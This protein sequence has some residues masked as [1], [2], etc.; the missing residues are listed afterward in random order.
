VLMGAGIPREI[1]GILDR[2]ANHERTSMRIQ[3]EGA[4]SEEETRMVLDPPALL[5]TLLPPLKRP[6]F[7]AI[8]SSDVL[9]QMLVQKA[10]GRIDGFVVE[11]ATAGGHNAP[12][13]GPLRL[14]ETGEPVYGPRD[15]ANLEKIKQ[16]GLP[17]WLAG[18]Y[19]TQ[20]GM[21]QALS[22]GATGVQIGTPFAFCEESGLEE[23]LKQRAL[24]SIAKGIAHVFTDPAASP[25]GFPFKILQLDETLSDDKLSHE[26]PR[27]CQLGFLRANYKRTDGTIG[28][29]CP[30]EPVDTYLKKSGKIEDTVGKQCL[31]N[32]LMANVDLP[33]EQLS[34]YIEKALVTAGDSI[35]RL[36]QFLQDGMTS[37]KAI[38]VIDYLLACISEYANALGSPAAA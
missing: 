32:A 9:A 33:Q 17:F 2:L 19:A 14:S 28:Y 8:V 10:N 18:D 1:P 16:I 3:I 7:L 5:G 38:D 21:Q 35:T 13:R 20:A 15:I 26:R 6:Q 37:Y 34:G 31:C 11:N 23:T 29:R 22:S 27:L 36:S 4:A 25:T 12:P 24:R 30:G